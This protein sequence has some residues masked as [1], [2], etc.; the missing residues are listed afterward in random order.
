MGCVQLILESIVFLQ[1]SWRISPNSQLA[2]RIK[3]R[4]FIAYPDI[5][6]SFPYMDDLIISNA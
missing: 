5:I 6:V 2:L 1:I 4:A 3:G